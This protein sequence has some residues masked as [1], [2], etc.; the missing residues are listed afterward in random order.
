MIQRY[1]PIRLRFGPF[2]FDLRTN[3]LFKN[4]ERIHLQDQPAKLLGLLASRPQELVTRHEIQN[5]SWNDQFVEVDQGINAA[6]KRI[7]KALEED[8]NQPRFI[9]TLAKKGYRFIADIEEVFEQPQDVIVPLPDS[10]E[11]P[12]SIVKEDETSSISGTT[13]TPERVQ[14]LPAPLEQANA[15]KPFTLPMTVSVARLLFLLIQLGYLAIYCAA[16]INMEALGNVLSAAGVKRVSITLGSV[17]LAGMCG[18]AVRIYLT[19]AVG[20]AHPNAGQQFRR[21]FPFLLMFDAMWAASPLL[22]EHKI[23]SGLALAG[24]VGL[25]YLPFAQRT[26]MVT[27]APE[28]YVKNTKRG[29]L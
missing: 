24:V 15:E 1:Q 6:M 13:V 26:L 2:E 16:L 22:V 8:P 23:G 11:D 10:T 25:A 21:L 7:R 3:E 20:W 29:P 17:L 19:T 14:E 12:S 4:G 5:L 9:Q 28:A 27:I 18:I